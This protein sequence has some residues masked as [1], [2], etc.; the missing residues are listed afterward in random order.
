MKEINSNTPKTHL[1]MMEEYCEKRNRFTTF[2][3]LKEKTEHHI[4]ELKQAQENYEKNGTIKPEMVKGLFALA[5]AACHENIQH[6]NERIKKSSSYK[7]MENHL[8]GKGYNPQEVF[9]AYEDNFCIFEDALAEKEEEKQ[10]VR[11]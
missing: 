1:K 11:N 8:R 5:N 6:A 3:D 2:T 4:E 7:L 9:D 10:C